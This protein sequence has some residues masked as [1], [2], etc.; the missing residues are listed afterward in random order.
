MCRDSVVDNL[1]ATESNFY[2]P[3]IQYVFPVPHGPEKNTLLLPSIG[4][5]K[6]LLNIVIYYVFAC[7]LPSICFTDAFYFNQKI[8][9]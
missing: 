7:K 1:S 5:F 6:N 4:N 2:A 8:L 9:P 3:F